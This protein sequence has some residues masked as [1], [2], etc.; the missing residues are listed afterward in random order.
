MN[1]TEEAKV[2]K[3]TN[4]KQAR[5]IKIIGIFMAVMILGIFSAALIVKESRKFSYGGLEF[6]KIMF[7]NLP[8]YHA[9]TPMSDLTGNVIA[10]YN[11]YLRNDPR[12]LEYIPVDGEI[13]FQHT[14]LIS[15]DQS[16]EECRDNFRLIAQ[17]SEFLGAAGIEP[18]FAVTNK[19]LAEE[20][21]LNYATC[22]G[23]SVVF[24]VDEKGVKLSKGSTVIILT[25]GE[26]S[27]I[28]R[29][30]EDC[31]ELSISNCENTQIIERFIIASAAHSKGLEV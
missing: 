7:D 12:D 8:L 28:K 2:D 4:E 3:K 5:Q 19:T 13:I 20:K 6:E 11:I 21:E 25:S 14:V 30:S 22:E 27:N 29:V 17:L 26:T 9:R 18:E 10:N 24:E 15:V 23:K 16:I 1:N 31:Y